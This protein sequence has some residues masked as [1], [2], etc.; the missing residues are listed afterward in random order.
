M[1][2]PVSRRAWLASALLLAAPAAAAAAWWLR[3]AAES[4]LPPGPGEIQLPDGVPLGGPFSLVDQD[5]QRRT[6]NDFRG[7]W[8][9]L[10]FGYT[11][12]PDICPTELATMAGALDLLPAG[13][14]AQISPV[15][16]TIDPDRDTPAQLKNYV[17]LFHPR[18][19]ALTGTPSEIGPVLKAFHV[20]AAKHVVQGASDYLMDHSSFFYLLGP[21]GRLRTLFRGGLPAAELAA[22]LRRRIALHTGIQTETSS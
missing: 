11:F 17:R 16:V 3:P 19:A 15:F 14:A 21:D 2:F 6:E 22:G 20:F 13:V 8:A 9:L 12:C 5:E 10:Y 1:A 7:R 18:L 4:E